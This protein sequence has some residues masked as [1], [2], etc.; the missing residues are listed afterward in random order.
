MRA[1]LRRPATALTLG[2]AALLVGAC[3]TQGADPRVPLEVPNAVSGGTRGGGRPDS[4]SL[5][6]MAESEAIAAADRDAKAKKEGDEKKQKGDALWAGAAAK[7]AKNPDDAADDYK[8]LADDHPENIHAGEARY[9]AAVNYV[10]DEDWNAAVAELVQYMQDYPV[11]PHL[12]RWRGCS[13][14][15]PCG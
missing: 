9:L 15:P 1:R 4:P 6:R 8:K 13:S 2:V 11:N 7:A 14:T 10:A 3:K 5:A 12:P